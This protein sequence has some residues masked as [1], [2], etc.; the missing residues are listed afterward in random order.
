VHYVACAYHAVGR[1]EAAEASSPAGGG[2]VEDADDGS[3]AGAEHYSD[4][5]FYYDAPQ[6]RRSLAHGWACAY[7]FS[8]VSVLGEVR[9]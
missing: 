2:D 1:G 4:W 6:C 7:Y 5:D 9:Q 3:G 8:L